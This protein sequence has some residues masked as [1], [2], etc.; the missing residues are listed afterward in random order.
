M[1][2]IV[3]INDKESY[4]YKVYTTTCNQTTAYISYEKDVRVFVSND[5]IKFVE[6]MK[7]IS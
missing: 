2:Y 3:E 5:F 1:R 6:F 4:K 7:E